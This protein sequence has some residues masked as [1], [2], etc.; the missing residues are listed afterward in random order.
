MNAYEAHNNCFVVACLYNSMTLYAEAQYIG[1]LIKELHYRFV[2]L[3]E[4]K[5]KWL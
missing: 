3:V 2:H 5:Y 4:V 1:P